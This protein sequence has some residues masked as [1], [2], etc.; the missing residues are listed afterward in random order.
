MRNDPNVVRYRIED[1]PHADLSG[2]DFDTA[3]ETPVVAPPPP[4][5]PPVVQRPAAIRPPV[6]SYRASRSRRWHPPW[7]P[8]R[9]WRRLCAPRRRW[10]RRQRRP[11]DLRS[12]PL[13]PMRRP[14][15]HPR[16]RRRPCVRRWRP[17]AR[18]HLLSPLRRRSPPSRWLRKRPP[19]R[20]NLHVPRSR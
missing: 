10:P 4:P 20:P 6:L 2:G 17:V 1:D 13:T 15:R 16:K 8:L 9:L 18:F 7:L 5:P 19:C 12:R 3:P 11:R 14:P